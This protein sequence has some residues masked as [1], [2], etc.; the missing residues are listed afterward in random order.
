MILIT[1]GAGYIGSHCTLKFLQEGYDVL[2]FDNLQNSSIHTVNTLSEFGNVEFLNCDLTNSSDV[3]FAFNNYEIEGVIHC[4]DINNNDESKIE[5]SKYYK[6]N[7]VSAINLLNGMKKSQTQFLVFSSSCDIYGDPVYFPVDEIHPQLPK[8]AYGKTKYFVEK[9]IN[10]YDCAYGI[11]S[12]KLRY[13]NVT[14]GYNQKLLEGEMTK[15]ELY[16]GNYF[17]SALYNFKNIDI[18]DFIDIEDVANAYFLAYTNLVEKQKTDV[19]NIG[20]ENKTYNFELPAKIRQFL[21][22]TNTKMTKPHTYTSTSPK[23]NIKKAKI[24]LGW[25]PEKSIDKSITQ[26]IIQEQLFEKELIKIEAG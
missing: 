13:F 8:T 7:L 2:I 23:M 21:R 4:A 12:A 9:M 26:T 5:P 6:N 1:G 24:V 3:D 16:S 20:A 15:Q 22:K 10:D 25:K 17:K 18:K 19:F 11:K 14:G